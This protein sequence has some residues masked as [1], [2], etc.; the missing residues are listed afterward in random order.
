MLPTTAVQIE[1]GRGI[2]LSPSLSNHRRVAADADDDQESKVEK[3]GEGERDTATAPAC[4]GRE[5]AGGAKV[6]GRW[7]HGCAR[8]LAWQR[9]TDGRT[10]R[11]AHALVE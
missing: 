11:W 7:V 3:Y 10:D 1:I 9:W 5:R 4:N 2:F 8:R 6:V